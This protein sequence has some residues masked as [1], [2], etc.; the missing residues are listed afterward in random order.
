MDLNDPKNVQKIVERVEQLSKEPDSR[1]LLELETGFEQEYMPSGVR[2]K[3]A[4]R[5]RS[6]R[7]LFDTIFYEIRSRFQ[8]NTEKL[9]E[10]PCVESISG[11]LTRT[12]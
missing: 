8:E 1:V 10:L 4:Q 12:L 5:P 6:R 2:I 3:T 7:E 11:E 9:F